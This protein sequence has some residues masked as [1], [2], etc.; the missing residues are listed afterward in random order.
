MA[1]PP[2][3]EERSGSTPETLARGVDVRTGVQ[4]VFVIPV[5]EEEPSE[6][7]AAPGGPPLER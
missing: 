6:E 3:P 2:E 5:E 7:D 4:R 1:K